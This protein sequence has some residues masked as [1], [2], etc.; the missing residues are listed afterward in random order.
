M[1]VTGEA[2]SLP[3]QWPHNIQT[4]FDMFQ[5]GSGAGLSFGWECFE[6][7]SG[8]NGTYINGIL[9]LVIPW[10]LAASTCLY[11]FLRG[12]YKHGFEATKNHLLNMHKDRSH[13]NP[14]RLRLIISCFTVMFLFQPSSLD[15]SLRTITCITVGSTSRMVDELD[16]DCSSQSHAMFSLLVGGPGVIMYLIVVPAVTFT[17]MYI[18]KDAIMNEEHEDH[19]TLNRR[20]GFLTAPYEPYYYYWCDHPSTVA[21]HAEHCAPREVMIMLRK[22]LFI[23]TLSVARP[24]GVKFQVL[25]GI[26][27]LLIALILHVRWVACLYRSPPRR[28]HVLIMKILIYCLLGLCHSRILMWISQS[29]AP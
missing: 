29:W 13:I 27:V 8:V 5:M 25:C 17:A 16:V 23:T 10:S 18:N 2:G 24:L 19:Y 22:V 28:N 14:L 21:L 3:F 20:Y 6:L 9:A 7:S 12:V 1:K 11:F 4:M 15:A 26:W